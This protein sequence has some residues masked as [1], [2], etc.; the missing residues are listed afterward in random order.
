MLIASIRKILQ[1]LTRASNKVEWHKLRSLQPISEQFGLERGTPID[2]YYIESFL[3]QQ[4]Q[5]VKGVALEIAESVYTKEFNSGVTAFEVLHIDPNHA[6]ATL[7]GDLSKPLLLPEDRIDCF[8][9]T[10]TLN[11]IFDVQ[12]AVIGIHRMLRPGG[13]ALVTVAGL[14]QISRYDM[15]RWGDF[16]RFT[17]KGIG[18]IFENTFGKDQIEVFTFGNVLSATALLQGI[19]VEELQPEELNYN[20]PNYQVVIAIKATKV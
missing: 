11:F 10:Q 19:S 20:D 14:T 8:I 15:D 6:Q 16:W 3:H 1:G 12:Q 4:K 17:N 5:H 13:T 2:R 7:V 18:Q 9:C